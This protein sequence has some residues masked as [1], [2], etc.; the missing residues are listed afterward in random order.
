MVTFVPSVQVI[1]LVP[2]GLS[3]IVHEVPASPG[4]PL[5]PASPGV[6]GSPLSPLPPVTVTDVPS[7]QV[8]VEVPSVLALTEQG[9][10][11]SPAEP[12]HAPINNMLA[13]SSPR[14]LSE[15][16]F[17]YLCFFME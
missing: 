10:P 8:M 2:S 5:A 4:S 11:A 12:S 13:A 9:V 14:L 17:A 15:T 1:V 7:G 3:T 16:G 6:P